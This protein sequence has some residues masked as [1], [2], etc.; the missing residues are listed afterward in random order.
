MNINY[1]ILYQELLINNSKIIEEYSIKIEELNNKIKFLEEKLKKYTAP[2]RNKRY[3]ESHKEELIKKN[4]EYKKLNKPSYKPSPEK[5]KEYNKKAYEKRK[6][7]QL[8][9][10]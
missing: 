4:K 2:E 1:E 7:K 8:E 9:E 3:Y 6:L 5:I 10:K